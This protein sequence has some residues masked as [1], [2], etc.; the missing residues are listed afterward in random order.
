MITVDFLEPWIAGI[1]RNELEY[2]FLKTKKGHAELIFLTN[3]YARCF[4][5]NY[6]LLILF[7]LNMS[8]FCALV[9]QSL[10]FILYSG[11][12]CVPLKMH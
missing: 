10:C 2:K 9:G 8:P 4:W 1:I 12:Y 6:A 5:T 3:V 11:H 7:L